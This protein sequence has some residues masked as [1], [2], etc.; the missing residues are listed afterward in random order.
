MALHVRKA[1]YNPGFGREPAS[2]APLTNIQTTEIYKTS[3]LVSTLTGMIIQ[4]CVCVCVLVC[5]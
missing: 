4:V 2:E 1:F 3:R 5:V